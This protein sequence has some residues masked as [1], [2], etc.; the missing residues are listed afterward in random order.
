MRA[1]SGACRFNASSRCVSNRVFWFLGIENSVGVVHS[2]R[3]HDTR[4]LTVRRAVP[5]VRWRSML[6]RTPRNRKSAGR[7]SFPLVLRRQ[8][9]HM[10]M[11]C[12][13][14]C[15]DPRH[16]VC[17]EAEKVLSR[18]NIPAPFPGT[19]PVHFLWF[20]QIPLASS[21]VRA[22]ALDRNLG[23]KTEAS[24]TP[25]ASGSLTQP[26]IGAVACACAR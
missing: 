25:P 17:L 24:D 4:K 1:A 14:Y 20:L 13:C 19:L 8:K 12:W 2:V 10:Q 9:G 18:G 3:V 23:L 16:R 21:G 15:S 26:V 11:G 6:W 7:S 22:G 5:V